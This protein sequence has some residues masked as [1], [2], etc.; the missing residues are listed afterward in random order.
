MRHGRTEWN[1]KELV[2]GQKDIPLDLEGQEQARKVGLRLKSERIDAIYSS[3]LTRVKQTTA[4]IA[5]FHSKVPVIYSKLIRE[6][7][8]GVA[9]GISADE[10][11]R[12]RDASGLEKHLYRPLGGENYEDL[13]SRVN[14]FLSMIKE[15]H[16]DDNVLIVAH[17]GVIRTLIVTI[18]KRPLSHIYDIMQSNAAVSVIELNEG[19]PPKVHCLNSTEHL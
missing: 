18:T 3:D 1:L 17:G 6:R 19:S 8:F 11:K 16:K 9:E 5:K 4:E 12:M 13:Q 2:Q 15:K 14:R 10:W 7:S